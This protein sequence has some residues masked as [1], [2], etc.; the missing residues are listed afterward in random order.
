M[1]FT[2]PITLEYV[3]QASLRTWNLSYSIEIAIGEES[4]STGNNG[5]ASLPPGPRGNFD[6]SF[7]YALGNIGLFSGGLQSTLTE[8]I[9]DRHYYVRLATRNQR[10]NARNEREKYGRRS[11]EYMHYRPHATQTVYA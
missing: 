4:G 5:S 7:V 3:R 1:V 8:K 2:D 6:G 11:R 9:F 10:T